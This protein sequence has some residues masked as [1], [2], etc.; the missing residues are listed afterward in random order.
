MSQQSFFGYFSSAA[1][2]CYSQFYEPYM[3]CPAL[4][5]GISGNDDGG[6]LCP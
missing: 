2:H 1:S 6:G 4:I 5:F 3:S